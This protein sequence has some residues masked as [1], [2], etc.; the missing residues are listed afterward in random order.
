MSLNDAQ[1]TCVHEQH[2]NIGKGLCLVYL[3]RWC[4]I[5]IIQRHSSGMTSIVEV[6]KSL[7]REAKSPDS[8]AIS[9]LTRTLA[10]ACQKKGVLGYG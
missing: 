8:L 10:I 9:L 1:Y 2:S 3:T 5:A 6:V 7:S 4:Y